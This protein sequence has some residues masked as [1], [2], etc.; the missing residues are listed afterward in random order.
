MEAVNEQ[1]DRTNVEEHNAM[2]EKDRPDSFD[3]R[4]EGSR[5]ANSTLCH[6]GSKIGSQNCIISLKRRGACEPLPISKASDIRI[7]TWV[8]PRYARSSTWDVVDFLHGSSAQ[9][10]TFLDVEG[11]RLDIMT[12]RSI[13]LC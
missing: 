2:S 7:G 3:E 13:S 4:I 5:G 1:Y 8:E 10:D 11:L 6:Q 9:I 12:R